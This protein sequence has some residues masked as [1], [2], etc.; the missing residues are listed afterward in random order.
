[1]LICS[2]L[3]WWRSWCWCVTA[4]RGDGQR[5]MGCKYTCRF[6]VL[7]LRLSMLYALFWYWSRGDRR[8]SAWCCDVGVG[9]A[10]AAWLI[11]NWIVTGNPVY[12][13]AYHLF[14]GAYWS[15]LKELQLR[16]RPTSTVNCTAITLLWSIIQFITN[17][18][19]LTRYHLL[20]DEHFAYLLLFLLVV[21]LFVRSHGME[22]GDGWSS[23]RFWILQRWRILPSNQTRFIVAVVPC[24]CWSL[25]PRCN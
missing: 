14:G 22:S 16:T 4:E 13:A 5:V 15:D 24:S 8:G 7:P 19:E 6:F 20:H 3:E 11:K 2:F 18:P 1:M 9:I 23:G 21:A 10:A 25:S 17:T 12:P